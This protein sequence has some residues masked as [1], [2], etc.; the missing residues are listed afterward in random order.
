MS[1]ARAGTDVANVLFAA[2]DRRW[3][4]YEGLLIAACQRAGVDIHLAR[5]LPPDAVDYVVYAPN[6]PLQDF[7]PFTRLKAV[8]NLWAG[9]ED[10]VHNATLTAPLCRMVEPGMTRGMVEWVT[11]HVLRHHL[12]MDGHVMGQDGVWRT[13][14]PPLAH[15][16]RVGMLGLGELGTACA[17]ALAGLGFD[18]A[19]WARSAKEIEGVDTHAG[20]DG[21]KKV[22][23]R[24][25]I[26]VLLVPL[27]PETE[28]LI[29]ADTLATMPQGTVLM[30]PGRGG[31]IDD[32]ALLKALDSGHLTH[33]TL[34]AFRVEPLPVDHPYWSH[35]RVTVTP[36][37][38]S[39]TRK[40]TA[41]EAIAENI[42]RG[43]AGEAFVNVVDRERAY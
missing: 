23:S 25:D 17:R 13:D 32:M 41:S 30:N 22:L 31:L 28:S 19:G 12:G 3:A 38:A 33:A 39:A 10:V 40:E 6:S 5:D 2:D 24:S 16:R 4:E 26:V 29:N 43:E 37:I 11:G 14:V 9:V 1:T 34:D 27:T 21:L 15:Q 7:T 36:H 35:P 42:R 8:L 18:V 20:P